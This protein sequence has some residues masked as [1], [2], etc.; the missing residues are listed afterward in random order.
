MRQHATVPTSPALPGSTGSG[1]LSVGFQLLCR[2]GRNVLPYSGG[3]LPGL[4]RGLPCSLPL[5]GEP[6]FDWP[7]RALPGLLCARPHHRDT[8]DDACYM[9]VRVKARFGQSIFVFVRDLQGSPA[10]CAWLETPWLSQVEK[11]GHRQMLLRRPIVNR[12][13]LHTKKEGMATLQASVLTPRQVVFDF[14]A[15]YTWW[16][17]PE[18][19]NLSQALLSK[20]GCFVGPLFCF[21]VHPANVGSP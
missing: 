4:Q 2:T 11:G 19:M 10:G 8:G 1:L 7:G 14:K 5:E 21:F 13:K 20:G 12:M 16:H 17:P 9:R 18:Y 6:G 15:L 3:K